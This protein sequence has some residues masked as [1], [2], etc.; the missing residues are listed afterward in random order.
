M[1]VELIVNGQ[2]VETR[3]IEAD[4][5]ITDLQFEYTPKISSWIAVRV[6]AAAHT[7]PVFVELDGKPI[8]ARARRSGR[9]DAVDV[10]WKQK[11]RNT[12]EN[13]QADAAAAYEV[14]RQAYRRVLA[15]A[16]GE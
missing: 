9:L 14:A 6:F 13:E 5:R 12:R 11:L 2:V 10:C 3:E 4:G 16:Q 8:R 7:N 1:P 15:E